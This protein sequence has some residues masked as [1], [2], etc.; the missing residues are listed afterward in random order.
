MA[1]TVSKRQKPKTIRV[2][3]HHVL[4]PRCIERP[5]PSPAPP[6][7]NDSAM[8]R[9]APANAPHMHMRT[10]R[11]RGAHVPKPPST[12]S[13]PHATRNAS[14]IRNR[15]GRYASASAIRM[16]SAAATA[17]APSP[18]AVALFCLSFPY[19][20]HR[21]RRIVWFFACSND[22]ANT[23]QDPSTTTTSTA[24]QA[25]DASMSASP[26]HPAATM[27]TGNAQDRAATSE[28]VTKPSEKVVYLTFDDGPSEHTQ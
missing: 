3:P 21:T 6:H 1:E 9:I 8:S 13:V 4:T 27:L 14:K 20:R 17:V 2:V 12:G 24:Q 10:D 15:A 25:A 26:S 23:G 18:N 7:R 5:T 19:C 16:A 11:A 22:D 28:S